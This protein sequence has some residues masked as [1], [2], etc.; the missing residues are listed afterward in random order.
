MT[1][2]TTVMGG[3]LI[4]FLI[5]W[6]WPIMLERFGVKGGFLAACLFIGL[7]WLVNHGAPWYLVIQSGAVFI[8]MGLAVGTASIVNGLCNGASLKRTIP[9]VCSAILGGILAG[10]ILVIL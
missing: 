10:F 9:L 8:D 1:I 3:F 4:G 7:G 5:L 2:L 6:F